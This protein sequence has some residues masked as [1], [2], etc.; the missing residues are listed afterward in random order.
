[1]IEVQKPEPIIKDRLTYRIMWYFQQPD[2]EAQQVECGHTRDLSESDQPYMRE[3]TATEEW[4]NLDYGWIE[5]PG[6]ILI[7]T[8][9]LRLPVNPSEEQRKAYEEGILELGYADSSG[10]CLIYPGQAL[11]FNVTEPENLRIRSHK[12]DVRYRINVYTK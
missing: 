11:P 7:E 6:T 8:F 9:P 12:G 10:G 1:M 3:L 5:N 2:R 4:Q